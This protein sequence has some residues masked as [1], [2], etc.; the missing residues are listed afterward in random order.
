MLVSSIRTS[1]QSRASADRGSNVHKKRAG[2]HN[3][4]LKYQDMTSLVPVDAVIGS[5]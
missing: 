2:A 1:K 4:R 3:A 5:S